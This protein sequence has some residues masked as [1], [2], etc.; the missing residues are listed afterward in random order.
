MK[1]PPIPYLQPTTG[2]V[3]KPYRVARCRKCFNNETPCKFNKSDLFVRPDFESAPHKRPVMTG[4]FHP[5]NYFARQTIYSNEPKH[6][7]LIKNQRYHSIAYFV[8]KLAR[9]AQRATFIAPM[10]WSLSWRT[11][12]ASPMLRFDTTSGHTPAMRVLTLHHVE[13][14]LHRAWHGRRQHASC[15]L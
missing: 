6:L 2:F 11:R 9:I 3:S 5:G 1:S 7:L 4:V 15:V 13:E 10:T 8:C 14:S 12:Y